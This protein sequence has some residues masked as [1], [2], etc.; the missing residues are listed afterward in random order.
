[1]NLKHS[2]AFF[3]KLQIIDA[4]KSET[5]NSCI[6]SFLFQGQ[7]GDIADPDETVFGHQVERLHLL[8]KSTTR[9]VL[10]EMTFSATQ[11]YYL[12]I[13]GKKE[14][15]I[16]FTCFCRRGCCG[17]LGLSRLLVLLAIFM[18]VVEIRCDT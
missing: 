9:E 11:I 10:L 4:H 7:F 17:F 6:L 12:P 16:N 2:E 14:Q 3:D 15:I 18:F 8:Q 5:E 1:M 13:K